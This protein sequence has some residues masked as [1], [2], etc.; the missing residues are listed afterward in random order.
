MTTANTKSLCL[1]TDIVI[2]GGGIAGLWLL[3]RLLIE[4]Y[5]VLLLEAGAL[6]QGQSIASQGII[7]GGL[8]YALDGN[9]GGAVNAIADMPA[10]WLACLK[11][12]GEL[13]LQT[14]RILSSHYYMWSDG[15]VRSRLKTFL[16]SKSL[17]GRVEAL[18]ESSQPGFFRDQQL[19]GT[20]YELPDFVV[21]TSSLLHSLADPHS[22]HLI[23]VDAESLKFG[24]DQSGNVSG[25]EF[26]S[27]QTRVTVDAR[28]FIFSAGAGNRDLMQGAKLEST[29]MQLRPL[30]MVIAKGPA[31]PMAFVHCIG[32]SFSLTPRLTLTSHRCMDGDIA[33]YMG[34]ELAEKGVTL[35]DNQ[36]IEV[37][38]Q[39]IAALF[40][41]IELSP[42]R[43]TAFLINRAEA[44]L[45]GLHRPDSVFLNSEKNVL[46]TWPTKFTLSPALADEVVRTLRMQQLE[47]LYAGSME[48]TKLPRPEVALVPWDERF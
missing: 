48:T 4:G 8:K 9:L 22:E 19:S 33:W 28:R 10:R 30:R 35:S 12:K 6:G 2:L 47:P 38:K 42:T 27:G 32:D 26:T 5:Q 14:C 21:D 34:G 43:W 7:H 20:V 46:I 1:T 3:N 36:Q 37:A 44:R 40:P 45:A 16:G 13:D 41:R 11:G 17:R 29:D 18:T 39:L 15:G 25:L 23:K 31:L 24:R